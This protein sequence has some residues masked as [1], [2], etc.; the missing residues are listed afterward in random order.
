MN[1]TLYDLTPAQNLI[2]AQ[3]QATFKQACM[4]IPI[5][6]IIKQKLD[7]NLLEE[8]LKKTIQRWDSFGIRI[9]Q[10]EKGV[11]KQYVPTP[12]S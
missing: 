4:N 12:K 9:I 8:S 10:P 1:R 11:Y 5:S 7:M 6:L 2:F 3:K